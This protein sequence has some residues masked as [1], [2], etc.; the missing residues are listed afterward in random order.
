[1]RVGR[2][3]R[4]LGKE[5]QEH[6]P[7]V[8]PWGN[9]YR[10]SYIFFGAHHL[11]LSRGRPSG[12]MSGLNACAHLNQPFAFAGR[13]QSTT[14]HSAFT[15]NNTQRCD[16]LATSLRFRIF[17]S[18]ATENKRLSSLVSLVSL[19]FHATAPL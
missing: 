9:I 15:G 16:T 3:E 1:M 14:S 19:V 6:A 10:P 7:T 2:S 4:D 11:F 8:H 13:P 5:G 18:Y 12:E 17:V